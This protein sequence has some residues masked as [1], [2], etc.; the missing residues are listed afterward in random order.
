MATSTTKYGLIKPADGERNWG[1][2]SIMNAIAARL[3]D[4]E[5]EQLATYIEGLH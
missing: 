4:G 5:M 1:K 2:A 3:S